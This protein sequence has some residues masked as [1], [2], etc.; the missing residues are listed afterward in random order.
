[1]KIYLKWFILIGLVAL[2]CLASYALERASDGYYLINDVD[3][4]VEYRDEVNSGT[5]MNGRLTANIDLSSVCGVRNGKTINWEPI[6]TQKLA[7]KFDGGNKSISNLYI[8]SKEDNQAL[9]YC[10]NIIRNL[11]VKNAYVRGGDYTAGVVALGSGSANK[12]HIDNTHFK[13]DVIGKQY[14]GALCAGAE[15]AS[16]TITNCSNSGLI[17][18]NNYVGGL[19]GYARNCKLYNCY[20]CGRVKAYYVKEDSFLLYEGIAGGLA[21]YFGGTS[22]TNCFN[23]GKISGVAT[24]NMIGAR[25]G[26][27]SNPYRSCFALE[28]M[29]QIETYESYLTIYTARSFQNGTLLNDLNTYRENRHTTTT[30]AFGSTV[31]I[32]SWKQTDGLDDFPHFETTTLAPSKDYVIHYYGDYEGLDVFTSTMKLPESQDPHF[33]YEFESNF[34]GKNVTRDTAVYVTKRLNDNF[35]EK[36]SEGFYLIANAHDLLLFRDAVNGG[37]YDIKGR[38]TDNID[39][40]DVKV[41]EPIGPTDINSDAAFMGEFDGGGYAIS[42]LHLKGGTSYAG[43]FS[44]IKNGVVKDVIIQNSTFEGNYAG[45]ICAFAEDA[46]ILNCGNEADVVG[47]YPDGAAGFIAVALGCQVYNCYNIG[48]V[49]GKGKA[50]GFVGVQRQDCIFN[51]CYAAGD[52]ANAYAEYTIVSPFA[53]ERETENMSNCFYDSTLFVSNHGSEDILHI[54]PYVKGLTTSQIKSQDFI[55]YL[56]DNVALLNAQQDQYELQKWVRDDASG[57]PKTYVHSQ[58]TDE[59]EVMADDADSQS[60]LIVYTVGKDLYIIADRDGKSILYNS[61]GQM[62]RIIQYQRGNNTYT[63]LPL[64]L[65]HIERQTVIVK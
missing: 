57:Y 17:V 47:L 42:G 4:F 34:N 38:V 12:M 6:N 45:A 58:V 46:I 23:Y 61:L 62:V 54:N 24:G 26:Q 19:V 44:K 16:A 33:H 50:S 32:L 15:M 63:N 20:N 29:A 36:D 21:G 65:Y 9:F 25:G 3:D 35:M 48:D 5:A 13:G 31:S 28:G 51:N 40:S 11:I 60:K 55:D 52:V 30:D 41:W 64:G 2:N 8:D 18:G 53:F 37:A 7:I 43:L 14:V 22:F 56:N 1:M 49:T 39:M 27:I 59:Q 10:A